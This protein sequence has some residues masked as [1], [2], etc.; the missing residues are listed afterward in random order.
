M[1]GSEP[2]RS[3]VNKAS[4]FKSMACKHAVPCN[5]GDSSGPV[6]RYKA[7]CLFPANVTMISH[8]P[9]AFRGHVPP[10]RVSN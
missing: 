2:W 7:D 1:V 6:L 4:R 10:Q 5:D 8:V 3:P 9:E